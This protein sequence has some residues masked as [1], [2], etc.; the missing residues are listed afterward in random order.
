M[1]VPRF[2]LLLAVALDGLSCGGASAPGAERAGIREVV[3]VASAPAELIAEVSV[4]PGLVERLGADASA[5]G[6]SPSNA[7]LVSLVTARRVLLMGAE[8]EPWAQ[9][10]GLPPSRTITL[11][12]GLSRD[13]FIAT[14]TVSHT[15]GQ[16]PSH[17]H[18]GVVLTVWT[19]PAQLR[20]MVHGAGEMLAG[21]LEA[22]EA[23]DAATQAVKRH[24]A[25]EAEVAAYEAAIADLKERVGGRRLFAVAHGLEYVARAADAPL[26]V[27]LLEIEASGERNDH[28]AAL[29]EQAAAEPGHAGVLVWLGPIDAPFEKIAKE[30]L[31]LTSVRVDLGLEGSGATLLSRMTKSL[32]GLSAAVAP[33]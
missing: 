9:R 13:A 6:W 14:A 11:G 23:P 26:L 29:L 21:V 15:H 33:R 22:P 19:D 4:G 20:A 7:D 1:P 16:G 17:S 32:E 31:G 24:E 12:D 5:G 25:F 18:G 10:A 30:G 8:F 3:T 28:A 27:T 2:A